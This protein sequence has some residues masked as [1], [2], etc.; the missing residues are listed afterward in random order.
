LLGYIVANHF[1]VPQ[2]LTQILLAFKRHQI[3]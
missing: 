1:G 3:S 2:I